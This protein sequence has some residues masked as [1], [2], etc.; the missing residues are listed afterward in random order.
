MVFR[1]TTEFSPT[2]YGVYQGLQ[3]NACW[4]P[5]EIPDNRWG[6]RPV[7]IECAKLPLAHDFGARA[8]TKIPS[9]LIVAR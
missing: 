9:M 3:I 1:T 8:K 7:L 2:A 5:S 6:V 4:M